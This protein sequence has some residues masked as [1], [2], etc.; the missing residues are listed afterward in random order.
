M[1]GM[2]RSMLIASRMCT[3]NV[4]AANTSLIDAEVMEGDSYSTQIVCD[5]GY[6]VYE[7]TIK[8][9]GVDITSTAYDPTYNMIS[10]ASVTDDV[11]IDVD[12]REFFY[13][14]FEDPAVEA[15]CVANWGGNYEAGKISNFEAM[16]VTTF[17]NK[18]EQNTEIVKFNEMQYFTG[19]K[20]LSRSVPGQYLDGMTYFGA[21]NRCSNLEEITLP[22][23]TIGAD[24]IAALFDQCSKLKTVDMSPITVTGTAYICNI[25]GK[26]TALTSAV[27]P[28]VTVGA[29][30]LGA[31][32]AFNQCSNLLTV[33][34]SRV[35]FAN[36]SF[37]NSSNI[38]PGATKLTRI[39]GGLSGFRNT[40]N[41]IKSCPLTHDAAVE[42]LESLGTV[43]SAR[44]LTLKTS[45]YNTLT[46]EELA[47]A[48]GKGW[49]VA[50]G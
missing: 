29:T 22:T 38:F 17:G 45:T 4:L 6:S 44:T 41:S 49:T 30:Y 25:C 36:M 16:R 19:L 50:K 8:M 10:I 18:F 9:G 24:K 15:I 33:D 40:E 14:T 39:I 26:C 31:I 48:T 47:I 27:L 5:E 43:T 20:S 46:A 1:S 32:Y 23:A 21:F 12:A 42:L 11:D 7:I 37:T 3:I 2:R 34:A 13:I 28:T 35:N